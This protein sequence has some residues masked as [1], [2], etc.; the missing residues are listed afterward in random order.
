MSSMIV[1]RSIVNANLATLLKDVCHATPSPQACSQ[2][3]ALCP[4]NSP[5]RGKIGVVTCPRHASQRS[6][7]GM[8]FAMVAGLAFTK[9]GA[10]A[11]TGCAPQA[12]PQA[13]PG[14]RD[15]RMPYIILKEFI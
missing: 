7:S 12:A 5:A 6:A 14:A 15:E 4:I 10:H 9:D 3:A 13:A 2:S 11:P 8:A 1:L